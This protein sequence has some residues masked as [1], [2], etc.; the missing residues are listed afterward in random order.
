[1]VHDREGNRIRIMREAITRSLGH[2][3]V[4]PGRGWARRETGL[5]YSCF[6]LGL[7]RSF[8]ET[9]D[10]GTPVV[11]RSGYRHWG[12]VILP[13]AGESGLVF[14]HV[15]VTKPIHQWLLQPQAT[16]SEIRWP[17]AIE[18]LPPAAVVDEGAGFTN[19][20]AEVFALTY[21][22]W[23]RLRHLLTRLAFKDPESF[24]P[25]GARTGSGLSDECTRLHVKTI[26]GNLASGRF[27]W[28][29]G[30]WGSDIRFW[31]AFSLLVHGADSLETIRLCLDGEILDEVA[32]IVSDLYE[33]HDFAALAIGVRSD[34]HD[35]R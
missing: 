14:H 19:A 29:Y 4:L 7:I 9:S 5:L 2:E 34:M 31:L 11:T 13:P 22:S 23:S 18:D 35:E 12:L 32:S 27:L 17:A 30:C 16:D 24:F 20:H 21:L 15:Y 10:W 25:M 6:R 26:D 8:Y 33:A 28:S 1:M 3:G